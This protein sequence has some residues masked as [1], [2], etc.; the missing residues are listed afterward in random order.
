MKRHYCVS[1]DL[2][3]LHRIEQELESSGVHRPKIIV[4]SQDD[5]AV[6]NHDHLHNIES[7]FRKDRVQGTIV[8]SW[9]RAVLAVLVLLVTALSD[10]PGSYTWMPFIFLSV[11][12]FG[13]CAWSRGLYGIQVPNRYFKRCEEQL[14]KG[15]HVFI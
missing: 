5:N 2:D 15:R 10:W 7:V 3:D 12:L 14:R 13:F 1:A 9:I 8:G 6:A 4:F 11:V